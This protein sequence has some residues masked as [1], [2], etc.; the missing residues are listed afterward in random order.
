MTNLDESYVN[1]RAYQGL[2][3]AGANED[4]VNNSSFDI[5]DIEENDGHVSKVG[6]NPED[7]VAVTVQNYKKLD[8]ESD[9]YLSPEDI[10][11]KAEQSGLT[12]IT[13]EGEFV[14]SED[15]E[16]GSTVVSKVA[17][18]ENEFNVADVVG[19]VETFLNAPFAGLARGVVKFG[20]NALGASGLIDQE[21]I[22]KFIGAIDELN[23]YATKDNV[24][25]QVSGAVGE[26][27]GQFVLPAVGAYNK[28]RALGANPILAS[29]IAESGVGLVGMSP[30]E[31]NIFDLIPEDSEQASIVRELLGTDPSD[32][33]WANRA[34]NA[35]ESLLLLGASEVA[36]R[37]FIT[38]LEKAKTISTSPVATEIFK[39]ID[40]ADARLNTEKE[41]GITRM[42]SGSDTDYLLAGLKPIADGL[43]KGDGSAKEFLDDI[44]SAKS[45]DEIIEPPSNYANYKDD[46]PL[47]GID[48]NFENINT[49]DDV[50]EVINSVSKQYASRITKETKGV[51]PHE[52]TKSLADLLGSTP[53]AA[54]AA[55]KNLPGDVED[56][57]VRALTMRNMLVQSAETTDAMAQLIRDGGPDVSDGDYLRFR[58]HLV[59]HAQL[60]SQMKGVQ[61]EIARALSAFRIPAEAGNRTSQITEELIGRL[62]GRDTARE[63]ADRWLM[64]PVDRRAEF[65]ERSVYAKSKD[66]VFEYWING[67]LSG[68]RTHQVNMAGNTLFTLFQVPE[69]LTAA[70]VGTFTR[71]SDRVRFREVFSQARGA[72]E[73]AVDGIRLAWRAWKDEMPTDGVQKMETQQLKAIT[74]ENFNVDPNSIG[75]KAI[76][77]IGQGIRLPGR[78]LMAEDEFFKAVGYRMELRSL[79]TRK[80]LQARDEGTLANLIA[81]TSEVADPDDFEALTRLRKTSEERRLNPEELGEL[82]NLMLANPTDGISSAGR[83]FATLVTFQTELG[84]VGRGFQSWASKAPGARVIVPFIRTPTNIVKEFARRSPLAA[85]MPSVHKDIMAGGARRDLALAKI[86][87]GTSLMTWAAFLAMEG[88]ITGGGPNDPKMRSA[89]MENNKPYSMKIGDQ[90]VPYGRLEP[91]AMLFGSTADAVDFI[92]YSDDEESIQQVYAATFIGVM[93]NIG[94]KTF[95]QGIS[96]FTD[97]YSDPARYGERY[98]S[99][100]AGTMMPFSSMSK[101]ITRAVD[102]IIREVRPDPTDEPINALLEQIIN[103]WTTRIPGYSDRLPPKRTFWGEERRAYEGGPATAFFAFSPKEIKYSAVDEEL[104]RLNQPL[105]M[106]SRRIGNTELTFVQYDKLIQLMNKKPSTFL[107][108]DL[109]TK[110]GDQTMRR[111][112]NNLVKSVLWKEIQSDDLKAEYLKKIRNDYVDAAKKA[113]ARDDPDLSQAAVDEQIERTM[114]E[115]QRDLMNQLAPLSSQI[116]Q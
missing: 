10:Q 91:L 65:A 9:S 1:R 57:H 93:K 72:A 47:E 12:D 112:M 38:G 86:G 11:M 62:G 103:Q 26:I 36:I 68:L 79:T 73:G 61:T 25:A 20:A 94:D 27:G 32:P 42:L 45:V 29:I 51:I 69:R 35:S 16:K 63:I 76:D 2:E 85:A 82:Y 19:D 96:D 46:K 54:E 5:V 7:G 58:E 95:L 104:V 28:L 116:S 3:N 111:A 44:A 24:P 109:A 53:E 17:P 52:V 87:T 105:T 30:N 31:D 110:Y 114:L 13:Q 107:D 98:I 64:T 92:Q 102:P 83:D 4:I 40:D 66:V 15:P 59:R 113:L 8:N 21:E 50:K 37:T 70:G 33:E 41:Q 55:V 22:D 74:P 78:A 100:L 101:D 90:W 84:E 81:S 67:L 39:A 23:E 108:A 18:R 49:S 97:A 6:R 60:Q 75:G 14:F 34:R 56:L 99:N 77:Y 88:T 48:F 71:S 43:R 115:G 106:P 80:L 89:W